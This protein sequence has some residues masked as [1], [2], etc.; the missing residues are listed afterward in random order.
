MQPLDPYW[1]AEDRAD[2]LPF[3]IETL[4]DKQG[5]VYGMWHGTD[6]RVLY[7]RKDLVPSR[8][9]PGTSCSRPPRGSRARA[10]SP[11]TSTTRAGGRPRCSIISRC[12]G[13]R[14]GELVDADGPAGFRAAAEP[15]RMVRVMASCARPTRRA[16][17]RDR[18]SA[19]NDYQQLTSAAVAG[20]V[21]MFLGGS[22]QLRE[23]EDALSPEEFAKWEISDIPQAERGRQS[24]GTGGWVWVRFAP[25]PVRQRAATEFLRF[26]ESPANVARISI[27]T[28]QLP[29]RRSVYRDFAVFREN[30]W[31]EK[32]GRMVVTAQGASGR[33]DLSRDLRAAPAGGGLRR[34]R[35]EDARG[36][37]GRRLAG[38][39]ED[40]GKPA[41]AHHRGGAAGRS[42][43]GRAADAAALLGA[44]I[45]IGVGRR[46]WRVAAWLAP[47]VLLV[48][49]FL[50]YP[51]FDLLRLA[52][53]D[54]RTHGT[55]YSYGLQTLGGLLTDPDFRRS[56]P[57][58]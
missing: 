7:Y 44:A 42:P 24:T 53:T 2:F 40:R 41:R 34:V 48:T 32:F 56:S 11:A 16:P 43:A 30:P 28:R 22:W 27:R 17:R 39:A 49:V 51:I 19:N 52:F 6:C 15:R 18:C 54:A 58:R 13:R 36:G 1:P 8:R 5:H 50:V 57:S 9:G 35:R 3:T 10:R 26:V 14:A 20:D 4:S 29:V 21:A 55:R 45:L 25:D 47:A 37:G 38:G 46:Q 31:Y 23:L 12:S 33:A